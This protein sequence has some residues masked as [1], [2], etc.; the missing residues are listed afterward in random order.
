MGA[1]TAML[2]GSASGK[3]AAAAAGDAAT[4]QE[5]AGFL[6]AL[7]SAAPAGTITAGAAPIAA[8]SSEESPAEEAVVV[9]MAAIVAA[10]LQ[11][12]APPVNSTAAPETDLEGAVP[13]GAAPP[14]AAGQAK[15]TEL[16]N[17]RTAAAAMASATADPDAGAENPAAGQSF[18]AMVNPQDD[19][20]MKSGA[21]TG[22]R[23]L[24]QMLAPHAS[25][26]AAGATDA[27]PADQPAQAPA[28]Y[29]APAELIR[30]VADQ[31]MASSANNGAQVS[32]L[33]AT[34]AQA[35]PAASTPDST[36]AAANLAAPA[37]PGRATSA[38]PEQA[39]QAPVGTP[40]WADELGS[41]LVLMSLRGQH[42]G[43]LNL[44]PEHLGPLEVRVSVNQGTAN[45]WFGSQHADTRAALAEALPRLRELMASAGLNLGQTGVSQHAPRQGS[46]ESEVARIGATRS[47]A[48]VEGLEASTPAATRRIALGLV[49]TYA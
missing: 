32:E 42:E 45:V 44:T 30:R 10:M 6:A 27:V 17:L 37:Q 34:S 35:Q 36:L 25:A 26:A 47:A 3:T 38:V 20:T 43:S 7:E 33:P 16:A 46:R 48:A 21:Q 9:D 23:Q 14:L 5:G 29:A 49:D 41:H 11:S 22:L 18:A 31:V 15:L 1:A 24:L 4:E 2:V 19:R 13:G 28:T 40:R 39:L 12:A 8:G